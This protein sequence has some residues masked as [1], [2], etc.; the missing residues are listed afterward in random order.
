MNEQ[1]RVHSVSPLQLPFENAPSY[2]TADNS[3][4]IASPLSAA[5]LVARCTL[6]SVIAGLALYCADHES[7]VAGRFAGDDAVSSDAGTADNPEPGAAVGAGGESAGLGDRFGTWFGPLHSHIQHVV[8][9]SVDGLAVRFFLQLLSVDRLPAF[10]RLKRLGAS[11][12]NARSDP[13]HTNTLPNHIAMLTGLPVIAPPGASPEQGHGYTSNSDPAADTSIHNAGNPARTY[14]PSAFDVVHDHGLTTAMFAS[15]PKFSIFTN[16]Y[17]DAGAMDE[18]GE[19]NGRRKIDTVEIIDDLTALTDALIVTLAQAPPNFSFV[20]FAA[21]DTA[22]HALGWG[23]AEYLDAIVDVD[24]ALGRILTLLEN[25]PSLAVR[26]AVILTA[27]HGGVGNSHLDSTNP[28]NFVIPFYVL[29]PGILGGGDLYSLVGAQ[30]TAPASTENP[31][32]EM[33]DQP[34]RNGD[35]GNLAL[36]LLG[37]RPIPGSSMDSFGLAPGLYPIAFRARRDPR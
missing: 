2:L 27:D 12:E 9:I 1:R 29:G 21:P 22:G 7:T 34:I 31:G 3:V 33:R 32:F 6:S 13:T 11:T 14:T 25:E 19:D 37:L 26:T 16:S 20:H 4:I 10:A 30:R 18:V 23:S 8:L 15:K 36:A 28:D 5:K 17:N 24:A 35:S